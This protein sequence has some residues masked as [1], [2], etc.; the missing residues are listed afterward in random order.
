MRKQ[1]HSSGFVL[2]DAV[3]IFLNLSRGGFYPFP[4]Y[5]EKPMN[6]IGRTLALA[7]VMERRDIV[8]EIIGAEQAPTVRLI[9]AMKSIGY[10][11]E[12]VAVHCDV[13]VAAMRNENRGNDAISAYYAESFQRS[14]LIEAASRCPRVDL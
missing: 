7:A 11:V 5:F 3:E 14:W 12:V 6:M 8:T 9:E 10:K 4:E 1:A 2:L 13:H